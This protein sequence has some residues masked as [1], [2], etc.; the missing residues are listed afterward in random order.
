HGRQLKHS[1][2]LA[3][4]LR[5][6]GYSVDKILHSGVG[7]RPGRYDYVELCPESKTVERTIAAHS[8]IQ[9]LKIIQCTSSVIVLSRDVVDCFASHNRLPQLGDFIT[10]LQKDPSFAITNSTRLTL[11]LPVDLHFLNLIATGDVIHSTYSIITEQTTIYVA[12]YQ[13]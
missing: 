10:L 13:T 12:N 1:S 11:V 4:S 7:A 9:A 8:F 2:T 6:L 3:H 5:Q